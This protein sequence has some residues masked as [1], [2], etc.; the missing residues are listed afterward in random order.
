MMST[1][2]RRGCL[3]LVLAG[4]LTPLAFSDEAADALKALKGTWVTENDEAKWVFDGDKVKTTVNGN[5]YVS[6][7]VIVN[8]KATPAMIDFEVK[9][10]DQAGTTAFGIYKLEGE[11]LSICIAV[12]GIATRPTEFTAKEGEIYVFK[13]KK[14]N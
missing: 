11:N 2:T 10:G 7:A 13:L 1:I 14:K 4:I 3:G 12:P 5:D 6:K 9:E 8:A